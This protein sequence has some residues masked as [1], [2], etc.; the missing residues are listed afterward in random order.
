MERATSSQLVDSLLANAGLA[1]R[2]RSSLARAHEARDRANREGRGGGPRK[3]PQKGAT[4]VAGLR[5]DLADGSL[6]RI[7]LRGMPLSR[8][9]RRYRVSI[10]H[11]GRMKRKT[12]GVR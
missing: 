7:E 1:L 9:A 5:A 2:R 12:L 8:V 4:G 11:A 3:P 6:T 10:E